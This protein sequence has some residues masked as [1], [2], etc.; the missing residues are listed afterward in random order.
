MTSLKVT[1]MSKLIA[2]T[3]TTIHLISFL[4]IL[5]PY[6]SSSNGLQSPLA[7]VET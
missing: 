4:F 6:P 2:F 3:E 1:F 5:V 7:I